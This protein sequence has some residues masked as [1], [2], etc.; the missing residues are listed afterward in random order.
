MKGAPGYVA[1]VLDEET[2]RFLRGLSI[3][4][5][6]RAS[7][8]TMAY[9]PTPDVYRRYS[10][11]LGQE[12]EFDMTAV[13]MDENC[14]A[15]VVT[16]V[17]SEKEIPHVTISHHE[18]VPSSHSNVMLVQPSTVRNFASPVRGRGVVRWVQG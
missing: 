13:H 6:V 18:G 10:P 17:P 15:V 16:G 2:Q 7:H 12:I 9:R 8:V 3:F 11:M 1:C 5:V 4:S 14:Q